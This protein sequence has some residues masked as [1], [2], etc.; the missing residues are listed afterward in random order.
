MSAVFLHP[1][2]MSVPPARTLLA[3]INA[4]VIL[5]WLETEKS[6]TVRLS[7]LTLIIGCA[8]MQRKTTIQHKTKL[9]FIDLFE[10]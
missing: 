7:V 8:G 10:E 2:V 5:D 9:T 1:C 4:F 3:L 6:V